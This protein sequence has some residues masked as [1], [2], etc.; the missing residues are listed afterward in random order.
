VEASELAPAKRRYL[1]IRRSG[2][3]I[4]RLRMEVA[5][6]PGIQKLRKLRP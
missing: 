2:P 3:M 4:G 6:A 1:I 5:D